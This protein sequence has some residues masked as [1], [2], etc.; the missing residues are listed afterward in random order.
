MDSKAAH[1]CPNRPTE[2]GQN[3]TQYDTENVTLIHQENLILGRKAR[4]AFC[5]Q[6]PEVLNDSSLNMCQ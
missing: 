1:V 6:S 3:T 4:R 5:L 2:N